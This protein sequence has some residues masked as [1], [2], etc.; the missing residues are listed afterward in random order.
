M[1]DINYNIIVESNEWDECIPSHNDLVNKSVDKVCINA[2]IPQILKDKEIE[3]NIILTNDK[4]IRILN[5]DFRDLDKT[6]NV[7]SFALIDDEDASMTIKQC[8]EYNDRIPAGDIMISLETIEREA[9][10]QNKNIE[11]HFQHILIHGVLHIL[12][13]DHINE[14]DALIMEEVEVR[15][16]NNMN[17]DNPYG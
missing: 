16:L 4:N 13:Y 5:E 6:T 8:E 17:I 1:T 15:L 14:E 11:H 9:K 7:L 3:I 12:G 2:D 10:E